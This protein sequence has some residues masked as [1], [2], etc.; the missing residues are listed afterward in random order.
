MAR[1]LEPFD[2]WY[3]GFKARSQLNV[4]KLD[5]AVS[6]R[7]PNT[8]AF[9][10]D[11]PFILRN[12]GF[13]PEIAEFLSSKITVDPS[14]GAGHAYGAAMRADNAHLRTRIGESGMN[15]KAYNIAIHELGHNVEQVLSLNRIDYTILQG[16]PN[17]AF[18]E[19]FAFVFQS[20]DLELLGM[21]H[22]DPQQELLKV[23]DTFWST[24][25]ISGVA[26]VD[27]YVWHWMYDN[28]NATPAQLNEAVQMIA[29][30]VWNK[31]YAPVFGVK[32]Q[33]LLGIYSHMIDAGL[34]LPD[35]PLGHIIAFQIEQYFKDKNLAQ[36]MERM[37]KLGSITP[38]AW[39]KAAVGAPISTDPLIHAAEE[40]VKSIK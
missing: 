26:L 4:E 35:Y 6:E 33:I 23:L 19:G 15:Y 40:A 9:Q 16:V 8:A 18:T 12:L 2:I 25:E 5:Q 11:L 17:T 36:E 32:D 27:M 37:C 30:D 34:Y 10:N 1:E 28:P 38:S 13:Q 22:Q 31:Y 24:Y 21:E 3:D 39:M 20:R 7:Y 29:K 14:R